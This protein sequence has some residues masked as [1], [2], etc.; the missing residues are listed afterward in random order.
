LLPG[1]VRRKWVEKKR[2]QGSKL[3]KTEET[4]SFFFKAL[5]LSVRRMQ[6]VADQN[7]AGMDLFPEAASKGT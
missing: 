4:L 3:K 7:F 2:R 5:S 6:R 1:L